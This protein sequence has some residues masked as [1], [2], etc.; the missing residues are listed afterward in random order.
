MTAERLKEIQKETAYPESTSVWNA[1]NQ[2]CNE[3]EQESNK[4]LMKYIKH[5]QNC[6]GKDFINEIGAPQSDIRFTE[7]EINILRWY[8]NK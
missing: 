5:V 4:L 2:A 8:G 1:L 6:E 7:E 3:T